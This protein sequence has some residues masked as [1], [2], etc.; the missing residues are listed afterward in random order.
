MM[1]STITSHSIPIHVEVQIKWTS[2][3]SR[4]DVE[5]AT[6]VFLKSF[7]LFTDGIINISRSRCLQ[8]ENNAP[9]FDSLA[10]DVDAIRIC[11]LGPDKSVSFWQAKILV[12][13]YRLCEQEPEKDYLE[14]EESLSAAEQWELPNKYLEGLWESI[15]VDESIKSKLLGYCD[16]SIQF[17]DARVDP[18]VIGWNRMMLLH[19]YAVLFI[20]NINSTA[21]AFILF[22]LLLAILQSSRHRQDYA[23]QGSSRSVSMLL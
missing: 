23:M 7:P 9:N 18:V 14:G 21:F 12:H 22:L 5:A 8:S 10:E 6:L 15:V 17:A 16:T 2:S 13:A 11:G 1:H 3:K 19:G 20:R 4:S